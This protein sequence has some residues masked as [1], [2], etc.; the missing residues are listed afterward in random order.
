MSTT[1]PDGRA[2][3]EGF[4]GTWRRVVTDPLGFF[5]DMPESGGLAAP[6]I[7]LALCSAAN[8]AGHL[9][10]GRGLTSGV[11]VFVGQVVSAYVAAALL[12]L[13]A[14]HLFG[15]RAG[16]EPT[17]RVVAYAAAPGILLWVPFVGAF[18]WAYGAYLV[19]RGLE[20]VQALDTTRAVLTVLV[21][22]G[23]LLLVAASRR[24]GA[25]VF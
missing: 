19:V 9:L 22:F 16:F 21:T 11:A 15:G 3:L 10:V 12:V 20:R 23:V 5:A 14:Q 1:E 6:T 24:G 18:A 8:A 7:F 17:L 13:V 4:V 2:A 25:P